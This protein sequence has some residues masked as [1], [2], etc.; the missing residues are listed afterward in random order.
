M[1]DQKPQKE[2]DDNWQPPP[3]YPAAEKG[4]PPQDSQSEKEVPSNAKDF[5]NPTSS[6][7]E[8]G[9]LWQKIRRV[10]TD[11]KRT[12][13]QSSSQ[14]SP[15][16]PHP[17][18]PYYPYAVVVIPRWRGHDGLRRTN[19]PTPHPPQPSTQFRYHI[20]SSHCPLEYQSED[21][22]RN[23]PWL[24]GMSLFVHNLEDDLPQQFP[25]R[26]NLDCCYKDEI[27]LEDEDP[28]VPERKTYSRILFFARELGGHA[29][30]GVSI[31]VFHRNPQWL[32]DLAREDIGTF[33]NLESAVR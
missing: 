8:K 22:R 20:Y 5:T 14:S 27:F 32:A 13:S 31:T 30:W 11:T 18:R 15:K 16:L 26:D 28:L 23:S 25:W 10:F 17:T 33:I 21:A 6:G 24:A 4:Q 9:T 12:S 7:T 29:V 2:E 19:V 1:L 3:P